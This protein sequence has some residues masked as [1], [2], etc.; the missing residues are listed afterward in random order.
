MELIINMEYLNILSSELYNQASKI[1]QLINVKKDIHQYDYDNF[2][3]LFN[4]W[5]N[6]DVKSLIDD[7]TLMQNS[8]NQIKN[9]EESDIW[10]ESLNFS[11]EHLQKGINVLFSSQKNQNT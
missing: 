10:I 7:I 11:V 3:T 4:E 1:A 8:L 9:T 6:Q 5:K 2:K